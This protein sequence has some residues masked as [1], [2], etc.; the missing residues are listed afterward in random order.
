[1]KRTHLC[2]KDNFQVVQMSYI[3]AQFKPKGLWYQ[4]DGSWKEWCDMEMPDWAYRITH[5]YELELDM[6][7]MLVIDTP[8]KFIAFSNEYSRDYDEGRIYHN[9]YID[10]PLVASRYT[11]I[12]ITHYFHQFRMDPEHHWYYP[13][14]LASGC[15]FDISIVKLNK[16]L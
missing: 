11:G 6:S 12:E 3:Q 4:I 15:V 8:E 1:M 5:E 9:K 16:D 7:N 2:D 14:D 13:W 10:W